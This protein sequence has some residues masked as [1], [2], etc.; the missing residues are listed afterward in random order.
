M[1]ITYSQ[2]LSFQKFAKVVE[3]CKFPLR[4]AFRINTIR[5]GVEDHLN[6]YFEEIS[7]LLEQYATKDINGKLEIDEQGNYKIVPEKIQEC[8]EK[9]VELLNFDFELEVPKL[10]IGDLETLE[11]SM[12]EIEGILPFIAE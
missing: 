6:F 12:E 4:T 1:K 11:I 5:R 3:H 10:E 2:A 8:N 7:K 9:I